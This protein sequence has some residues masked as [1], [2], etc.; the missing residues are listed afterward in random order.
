MWVLGLGWTALALSVWG[1]VQPDLGDILTI[2]V[3]LVPICLIVFS[4]RHRK[5]P[6]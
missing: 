2:L 1:H 5:K 6:N 3:L 4:L